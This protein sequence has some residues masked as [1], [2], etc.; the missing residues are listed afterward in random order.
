MPRRST[1][2][3][4]NGLSCPYCHQ[5]NSSHVTDSRDS[6]S[7]KHRRRRHEC[8]NCGKRFST[9]EITAIEYEKVKA[10]RVDPV[11]L[12]A[13]IAILRALKAH[14]GGINGPSQD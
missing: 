1:R 10:I 3:T 11:Q 7:G 4:R 2:D 9:Y 12:D 8:D 5:A 6:V 14:F 13:A